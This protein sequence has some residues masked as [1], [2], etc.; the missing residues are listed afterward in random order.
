MS[1]QILIH[2]FISIYRV[3]GCEVI[4]IVIVKRLQHTSIPLFLLILHIS[5]SCGQSGN[6]E[7][8]SYERTSEL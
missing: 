7:Y 4:V 2:Y 6:L 5:V 8:D 3:S 1:I